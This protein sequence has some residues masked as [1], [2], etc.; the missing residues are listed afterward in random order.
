MITTL[1][2]SVVNVSLPVISHQ[3]KADIGVVE[4]EVL[5]HLLA[6]TALLVISGRIGAPAA[7]FAF[8]GGLRWTFRA[9]AAPAWLGIV[10][11]WGREAM[12]KIKQGA[13]APSKIAICNLQ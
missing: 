2:S 10:M 1:D 13:F 3:L 8:V 7:N 6:V 4:W 12:Q 9:G 11:V 5:S